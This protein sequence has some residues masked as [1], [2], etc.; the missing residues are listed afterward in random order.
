MPCEA[1]CVVPQRSSVVTEPVRY[2]P[3]LLGRRFWWPGRLSRS[4]EHRAVGAHAAD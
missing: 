4:A 3:H 2:L 1:T